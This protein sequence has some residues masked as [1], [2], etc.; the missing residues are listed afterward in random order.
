MKKRNIKLFICSIAATCMLSGCGMIDL[1]LSSLNIS[2]TGQN[3]EE[4][5]KGGQSNQE[6]VEEKEITLADCIPLE[7]LLALNH[8]DGGGDYVYMD[9]ILEGYWNI[10]EAATGTRG[11]AVHFEGK[12]YKLYANGK[13]VDEAGNV[14]QKTP[15]SQSDEE[16]IFTAWV[17]VLREDDM[18]GRDAVY[19][20]MS[21]DIEVGVTIDEIKSLIHIVEITEENFHEYF[22]FVEVEVEEEITGSRFEENHIYKPMKEIYTVY[23]GPGYLMT[24]TYDWY[25]DIALSFDE[26]YKIEYLDVN[27]NVVDSYESELKT[28]KKEMTIPYYDFKYMDEGECRNISYSGTSVFINETLNYYWDSDKNILYRYEYNYENI[29]VENVQGYL[30]YCEEMPEEYWNITENGN[31]YICVKRDGQSGWRFCEYGRIGSTNKD[32]DAA[33]DA[34]VTGKRGDIINYNSTDLV[35]FVGIN[36]ESLPGYS[37][38]VLKYAEMFGDR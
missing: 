13:V 6:K 36:F 5:N 33:V 21:Y 8:R 17:L 18:L 24:Y 28:E 20:N 32:V 1:D 34:C 38:I 30:I 22:N 9:P 31:R 11:I 15:Q 7:D 12:I 14:K 37:E 26:N 16:S 19:N 2:F 4:A 29:T 23:T 3:K 35:N 27:D 10:K 25:V